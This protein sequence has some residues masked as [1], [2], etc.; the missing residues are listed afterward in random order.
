[1]NRMRF[2]EGFLWGSATSAHQ[3]EGGCDRNQWW[4]WEQ[5]GLRERPGG[6]IRDGSTSGIACDYL[7]RCGYDHR[8]AAEEGDA[9]GGMAAGRRASEPDR[10]VDEMGWEVYPEGLYRNLLRVAKLG[11]PV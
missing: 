2:P 3:V 5:Q 7:R 6:N 11:A 4:E 9:S 1:V 10:F 8:L